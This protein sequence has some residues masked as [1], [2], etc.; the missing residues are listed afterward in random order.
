MRRLVIFGSCRWQWFQ[1]QLARFGMPAASAKSQLIPLHSHRYS[2]RAFLC[3]S[4][5]VWHAILPPAQSVSI[6]VLHFS[7][8]HVTSRDQPSPL[9]CCWAHPP[10]YVHSQ[11]EDESSVIFWA[12]PK[13]NTG[14]CIRLSKPVAL[15][16]EEGKAWFCLCLGYL[17][18]SNDLWQWAGTWTWLAVKFK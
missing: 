4:T 2:E 16:H 1:R 14:W 6:V 15:N 5:G 9:R 13:F 12:R 11:G 3:F 8:N 7:V 10:C 18:K 17:F